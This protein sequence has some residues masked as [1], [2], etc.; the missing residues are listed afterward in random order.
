LLPEAVV[1]A[2]DTKAVVVLVAL[3]PDLR[4]LLMESLH[5][6]FKLGLVEKAEKLK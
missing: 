6:Q 3:G 5:S 2:H 4:F 1:V